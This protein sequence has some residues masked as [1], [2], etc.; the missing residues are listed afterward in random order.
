M[1][2]LGLEKHQDFSKAQETTINY[3]IY[4]YINISNTF[5]I[6]FK[7]LS[8][9]VSLPADEKSLFRVTFCQL[10]ASFWWQCPRKWCISFDN[11]E[12]FYTHGWPGVVVTRLRTVNLC[13]GNTQIITNQSKK[14][15]WQK[16]TSR[17]AAS[18]ILCLFK[19]LFPS[20]L[21]PK[22]MEVKDSLKH[23]SLAKAKDMAASFAWL[24]GAVKWWWGAS[25]NVRQCLRPL[26]W[27][28][29]PSQKAPEC[30]DSRDHGHSRLSETCFVLSCDLWLQICWSFLSLFLTIVINCEASEPVAVWHVIAVAFTTL[31]VLSYCR[32]VVLA[33]L[34]C[35]LLQRLS[36]SA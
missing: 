20:L 23:R 17:Q 28:Q 34:P 33:S 26:T 5:Q 7:Y 15:L 35:N 19:C 8:C 11:P 27:W 16:T 21:Q 4:I 18:W 1:Q 22:D 13:N 30:R 24:W 32:T 36:V 6:H 14:S 9:W 2:N 29:R 31:L 25:H 10:A 12:V 3:N